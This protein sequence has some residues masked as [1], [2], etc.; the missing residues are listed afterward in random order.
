MDP[1]QIDQLLSQ[2]A[3]FVFDRMFGAMEKVRERLDRACSALTKANVPYAIVGGNAVAAWVATRDDGAVR[4][5]KDVDIL[6]APESSE[7]ATEALAQVG[8]APG[9]GPRGCPSSD[10][11]RDIVMDVTVFLDGPEGKPSQ[12]LHV[13]WAGQKVRDDY[14]VAAPKTS[15]S[16][17]IDGKQIVDLVEL[18]RMKL[19]SNRDKDR[20]HVRDLI[21]VGLIDESWL[22]KLEP[23][24]AQRLKV[25]LDDPD[26]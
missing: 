18:L 2:Q 11:C 19:V 24:L 22:P 6:L 5:T 15:Q 25:L 21:A 7:A 9:D 13:I 10:H 20:V 8:L 17:D 16:R 23:S 26:G 1:E 12:G 3:P 14:V 4:S